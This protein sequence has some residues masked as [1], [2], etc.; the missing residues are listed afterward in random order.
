[1]AESLTD[2]LEFPEL[3]MARTGGC[4]NLCVVSKHIHNHR[5]IAAN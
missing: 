2:L 5:P 3:E 1:M 4:P